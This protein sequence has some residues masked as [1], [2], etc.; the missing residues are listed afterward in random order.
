MKMPFGLPFCSLLIYLTSWTSAIANKKLHN[1][2]FDLYEVLTKFLLERCLS[3]DVRALNTF[4]FHLAVGLSELPSADASNSPHHISWMFD[5]DDMGWRAPFSKEWHSQQDVGNLLQGYKYALSKL[6]TLMEWWMFLWA[7][8]KPSFELFC[9]FSL[10]S[11]IL[12]VWAFVILH[13]CI[14]FRRGVHAF[15]CN[16]GRYWAKDS[17]NNVEVLA[18][19]RWFYRELDAYILPLELQLYSRSFQSLPLFSGYKCL[20]WSS[21]PVPKRFNRTSCSLNRCCKYSS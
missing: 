1:L 9:W 11:K 2:S 13:I 19:F 10:A 4:A 12:P 7:S 3:F 16:Y 20:R 15:N 18:A 6:A 5:S 21:F 17:Q 14:L 8:M